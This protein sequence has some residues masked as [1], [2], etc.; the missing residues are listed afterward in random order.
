MFVELWHGICTIQ[1]YV[2]CFGF[3]HVAP[4]DIYLFMYPS[5]QLDF[6]EVLQVLLLLF[7]RVGSQFWIGEG[8]EFPQ[9]VFDSIKDNKSFS[10][11]LQS[12]ESS[13]DRPWFLAWFAEYLHTLGKLPVY[14]EV[15]VKMTDF[16]CEETQ[17]ERFKDARPSIMLAAT[18]VSS[19]FLPQG[20]IEPKSAGLL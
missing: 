15:L 12:I 11:L 13:A 4:L 8:P 18:R 19:V 2:S 3:L 9:V 1:D 16:L 14:G 7:K 5:N 6:S 17:H 20:S 10:D